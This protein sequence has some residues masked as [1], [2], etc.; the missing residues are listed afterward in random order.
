[1]R[2]NG[3][4]S[5]VIL[6]EHIEEP[7]LSQQS[8]IFG[9]IAKN[10]GALRQKVLATPDKAALMHLDIVNQLNLLDQR[11]DALFDLYAA[12]DSKS[13]VQ[14]ALPQ[15]WKSFK[16]QYK[17]FIHGL[18]EELRKNGA[19]FHSVNAK[20]VKHLETL[21][22][23]AN[24]YKTTC[25]E[26]EIFVAQC[27][28]EA[29][30]KDDEDEATSKEQSS[31]EATI[32]TKDEEIERLRKQL[33]ELSKR[34]IPIDSKKDKEVTEQGK[35][36]QEERIRGLEEELGQITAEHDQ[37]QARWEEAQATCQRSEAELEVA[38]QLL[39][40][41]CSN[42][43]SAPAVISELRLKTISMHQITFISL[44]IIEQFRLA[45]DKAG[46]ELAAREKHYDTAHEHSSAALSSIQDT[47]RQYGVACEGPLRVE[48]TL[49]AVGPHCGK[50]HCQT[51]GG[52]S[53][54]ATSG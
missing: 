9:D 6:K 35:K 24:T 2:E 33:G 38:R 53:Q 18:L 31:L 50:T 19:V 26:L 13:A 25:E 51:L 22:K 12:S 34:V 28:P 17:D 21:I 42:P 23:T 39:D 43:D 37:L 44:E 45:L 54:Q 40:Q 8:R 15:T 29:L 3:E 47:A 10:L 32:H 20:I 48:V 27:D 46:A 5:F 7:T 4:D 41:A 49:S 1:M 11:W 30:V 52:R 14:I 36:D 16:D